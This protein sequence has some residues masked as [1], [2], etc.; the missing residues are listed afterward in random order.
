MTDE[1]GD[2]RVSEPK[3]AFE[4]DRDEARRD[5]RAAGGGEDVREEAEEREDSNALGGVVEAEMESRVRRRAMLRLR[6]PE[7]AGSGEGLEV[8]VDGL[9]DGTENEEAR[10]TTSCRV[11][12][13]A[14][15]RAMS[16]LATSAVSNDGRPVKSAVL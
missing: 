10:M 13:S 11:M 2:E 7:R 6:E 4:E 8:D 15:T 14:G 9:E 16:L 1:D 12:S 5:L 3:E